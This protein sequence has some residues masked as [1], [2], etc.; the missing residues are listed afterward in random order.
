MT[1]QKKVR[2]HE[3]KEFPWRWFKG[4]LSRKQK[5]SFDAVRQSDCLHIKHSLFLQE[6]KVYKQLQVSQGIQ[7]STDPLVSQVSQEPMVA[8]AIQDH[9]GRLDFQD[10]Q[11]S[12]ASLE[13]REIK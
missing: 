5:I 2:R 13:S 7:V 11:D 3:E 1:M 8:M 12:L 10:L 9:Q 6:V 4:N